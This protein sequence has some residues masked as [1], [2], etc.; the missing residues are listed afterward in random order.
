MPGSPFSSADY[1]E[2]RRYLLSLGEDNS[3]TRNILKRNL[4]I[5]I[6]E[7]LTARQQ[8]MMKL[9]YVDR[10]KIGEIAEAL[11]VNQSTVSRTLKRGRDKL[12]KC[13]RYG[14]RELLSISQHE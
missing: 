8:L 7:E 13:L 11:S 4:R 14:A 6:N 2:Y 5:A 10:L 12:H 9:Y 1:A 3:A